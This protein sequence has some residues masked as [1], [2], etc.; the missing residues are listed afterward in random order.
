M[1][2][3]LLELLVLTHRIVF[4]GDFPD[5]PLVNFEPIFLAIHQEICRVGRKWFDAAY[6]SLYEIEYNGV[7]VRA[8]LDKL[9]G[10]MSVSVVAD[11]ASN[12]GLYLWRNDT[13]IIVRDY[14]RVTDIHARFN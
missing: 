9:S 1:S 11:E 6:G 4:S 5:Y 10:R 12:T 2:T 13:S 8:Y 14:H 3:I 7:L